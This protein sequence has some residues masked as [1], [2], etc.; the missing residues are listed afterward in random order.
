LDD[1]ECAGDSIAK[2][3]SKF[4]ESL[5]ERA[6]H[7]CWKSN[8]DDP[9]SLAPTR[10]REQ[11]EVLVFSHQNSYLRTGQRQD[12]IVLNSRTDLCERGDVMTGGTESGDDCE[13]QLS[14][15]RKRTD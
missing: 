3:V 5:T 14:S 7:S 8:Q 11:T 13:S 4:H 1:D 10:I 9:S 15:T 6:S 12:D 2:F